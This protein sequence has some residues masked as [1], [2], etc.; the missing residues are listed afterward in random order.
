[1]PSAKNK[2]S[3]SPETEQVPAPLLS[4]LG[5]RHQ[6]HFVAPVCQPAEANVFL[7]PRSARS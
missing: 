4:R 2:V 3:V 5:I 7:G 1:M 6:Y